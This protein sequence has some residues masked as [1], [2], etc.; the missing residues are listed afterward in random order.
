MIGVC[1]IFGIKTKTLS[2]K[3][4][5]PSALFPGAV[6]VSLVYTVTCLG[7][8]EINKT[9]S[10]FDIKCKAKGSEVEMVLFDIICN[11]TFTWL[12]KLFSGILKKLPKYQVLASYSSK[13]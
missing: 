11:T 4:L 2:M 12:G 1:Q 7:N 3:R 10:L 5:R 6:L 13:F 9:N 8:S